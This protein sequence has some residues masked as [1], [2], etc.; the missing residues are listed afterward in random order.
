[1]NRYKYIEELRLLKRH[2]ERLHELIESGEFYRKSYWERRKLIRRIKRLYAKLVGPL[3][4]ASVM[5]TLAAAGLISVLAL[6]GCENPTGGNDSGTEQPDDGTDSGS[7]LTPITFP[8]AGT[9][10]GINA[11]P[12]EQSFA[13]AVTNPFGSTS[14]EGYGSG[15]AFGDIDSDGDTDVLLGQLEYSSSGN[16]TTITGGSIQFIENTGSATA[17]QF[18]SPQTDPLGLSAFVDDGTTLS[19]QAPALLADVDTDGDADLISFG[20]YGE[21]LTWSDNS[22]PQ[23]GIHLLE[24]TGSSSSPSFPSEVGSDTQLLADVLSIADYMHPAVAD[25]DGDG[26][27]ELIVRG[28]Q[29]SGG[30]YEAVTKVYLINGTDSTQSS[31]LTSAFDPLSSLYSYYAA[32]TQAFVDLDDDGDLDYVFFASPY[33]ETDG[34]WG[35][36]AAENTGTA[37]SPEFAGAVSAFGPDFTGTSTY[38]LNYETGDFSGSYVFGPS[39]A[40][41][42]ADGDLDILAADLTFSGN[43]NGETGEFSNQTYSTSLLF[44]ENTKIQ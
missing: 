4:S 15:A 20:I 6:T 14:L 23:Y 42:D 1:M 2:S 10:T 35:F 11:D 5:K 3:G 30:T 43:Y 17:P 40:D 36:V 8:T 27:L 26:D 13:A 21:S 39:V 18:V 31:E 24:N 28:Y 29:Y 38:S 32:S 22:P 16:E 41:I 9:G 25:I 37:S 44:Y 12:I 34:R 19:A 7:D 33:Y